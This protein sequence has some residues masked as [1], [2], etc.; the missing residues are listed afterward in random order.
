MAQRI[1]AGEVSNQILD[2][3]NGAKAIERRLIRMTGPSAFVRDPLRILRAVRFAAELGFEIAPGTL[4]AMKQQAPR[5]KESA[6]ERVLSELM[7]IYKSPQSAAFTRLMDEA[8]VLGVIFPEIFTMKGCT[9][10]SFHHKD[11]WAI[12]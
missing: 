1:A 6:A 11:V 2:P 8:E 10:N 4:A 12:P 7:R 3:F 9:Q 5:L